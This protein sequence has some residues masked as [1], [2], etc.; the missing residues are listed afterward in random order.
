MKKYLMMSLATVAFAS[1]FTSCSNDN[2]VSQSNVSPLL[3]KYEAA[4]INKFGTPAPTQTWGFGTATRAANTNS[5]QWEDQGY[6]I[7][8]DIT[9]AELEKVLAVFNQKGKESYESLIDLDEFFVQQVYKGVASYTNHAGDPVVG[10]EH[11]DWL[12]AVTKKTVNVISYWPYEEEV[13]EGDEYDD[14]INNF[15]NGKCGSTATSEK[16]GKF[17]HDLQLMVNSNTYKFG[18]KSSED[19]GHVFYNFRMEEIDGNY[20]VGFD[21]EANGAN[22][23]EQVDRDYIYNDWIVKIVPG[24]GVEKKTYVDRIIC[25]DLGNADDFDFNDVVFDVRYEGNDAYVKILNI[26][27]TLPLFVAG[28]EVHQM[29]GQVIGA[30]GLYQIAGEV[31]IPE[32][33]VENC[34]KAADIEIKVDGTAF[35]TQNAGN[36]TINNESAIY[37]LSAEAGKVPQKMRVDT[38]YQWCA[39]RQSIAA[40]YGEE[41]VKAYVANERQNFYK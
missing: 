15:N 20:Y 37:T 30:N 33:K 21:F 3:P 9:E 13:V 5:N 2:D 32:F 10:S 19:N 35:N 26:G 6:V 22:P 12:C 31:D 1:A 24:K 38:D 11:M 27:G 39:E 16:T 18:F 25:E 8:E 29:V 14:H 40:K 23:N 28:N 17:I 41:N 36:V 4:F 34:T 7:P